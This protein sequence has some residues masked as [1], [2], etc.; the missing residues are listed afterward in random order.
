LGSSL[1]RAA[2]TDFRVS[3]ERRFAAV[4]L[5]ARLYALDHAGRYPPSLNAL[6]PDYLPLLPSDPF[7]ADG[8]ALGY[9]IAENGKRPIVYSV[10]ENGRSDTDAKTVFP[11]APIYGW[12][13][14]GLDQWRD[15]SRF[16][17]P[18][19]SQPAGSVD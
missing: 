8:R 9:L 7:A 10:D 12:Q 3:A 16:A 11:P 4:A 17:P 15:L 19:S 13:T 1:N 2:Q 5:A 18:P 14:S 6:V